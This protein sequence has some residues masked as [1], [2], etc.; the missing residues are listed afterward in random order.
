MSEEFITCNVC[1]RQEPIFNEGQEYHVNDMVL[2]AFRYPQRESTP[3]RSFVL[4]HECA[5][6]IVRFIERKE[7][8]GE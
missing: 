3:S 4:C 1:H 6:K 8:D 2:L 5:D 7:H